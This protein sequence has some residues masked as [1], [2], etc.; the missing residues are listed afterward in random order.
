MF[1]LNTTFDICMPMRILAGQIHIIG[2]LG[3]TWLPKP[4]GKVIDAIEEEMMKMKSDGLQ[5]LDEAFMS[6]IFCK[7]NEM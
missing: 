3:Y 6:S 4:M 5:F 7:T 1:I 2:T